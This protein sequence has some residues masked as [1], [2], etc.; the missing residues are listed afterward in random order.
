MSG[1]QR[2]LGQ[3][4]ERLFLPLCFQK[5][6]V[7]VAITAG[8]NGGTGENKDIFHFVEVDGNISGIKWELLQIAFF[9]CSHEFFPLRTPRCLGKYTQFFHCQSLFLQLQLITKVSPTTSGEERGTAALCNQVTG[10]KLSCWLLGAYTSY[11]RHKGCKQKARTMVHS[12]QVQFRT[13]QD[14]DN[15]MD[16]FREVLVKSPSQL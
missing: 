14:Y 2:N 8:N 15:A 12:P 9:V 7:S 3:S 11:F 4:S 13:I 10:M 16:R 6:R 5:Y 1:S